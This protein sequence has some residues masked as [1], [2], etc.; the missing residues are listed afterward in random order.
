MRLTQ[1]C[2]VVSCAGV[3]TGCC[4]D[5]RLTDPPETK[6]K[7]Q[8]TSLIIRTFAG[9]DVELQSGRSLQGWPSVKTLG[10]VK[11]EKWS[12]FITVRVLKGL[13]HKCFPYSFLS[14]FLV[15]TQ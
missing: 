10:D 12:P 3:F 2:L 14:E 5:L 9:S 7:G 1:K 8:N 6:K 4:G 13:S 15:Y 11:Q